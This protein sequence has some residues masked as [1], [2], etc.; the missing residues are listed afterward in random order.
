MKFRKR[1]KMEL[2]MKWIVFF[3]HHLPRSRL[4]ILLRCRHLSHPNSPIIDLRSMPNLHRPSFLYQFSTQ[5]TK[6]RT[7]KHTPDGKRGKIGGN[8]NACRKSTAIVVSLAPTENLNHSF[9]E[10]KMRTKK[11]NIQN[12]LVSFS[13]LLF[14]L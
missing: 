3:C 1:N 5:S 6:S 4:L 12:K 8:E 2:K 7:N 13:S 9:L 11:N 14:C 10:T